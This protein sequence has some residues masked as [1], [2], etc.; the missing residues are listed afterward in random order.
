MMRWNTRVTLLGPWISYTKYKGM[1]VPRADMINYSNK[2]KATALKDTIIMVRSEPLSS[3]RA[4]HVLKIDK[5]ENFSPW[6]VE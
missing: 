5:P 4:H 2:K 6:S 1:D 3:H